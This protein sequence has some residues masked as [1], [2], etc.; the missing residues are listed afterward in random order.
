MAKCVHTADKKKASDN[1]CTVREIALSKITED[2]S[3][4]VQ[5]CR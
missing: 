5:Y 4:P 3:K 1:I 2:K